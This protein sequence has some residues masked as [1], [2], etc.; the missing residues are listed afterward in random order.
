MGGMAS[1]VTT[2][3]QWSWRL[4]TCVAVELSTGAFTIQT[5]TIQSTDHAWTSVQSLAMVGA[6]CKGTWIIFQKLKEMMHW[7]R[8]TSSSR[9]T[10][11]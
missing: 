4:H 2:R 9:N 3:G 10:R 11:T 8:W 7:D 1:K 6:N 5:Q